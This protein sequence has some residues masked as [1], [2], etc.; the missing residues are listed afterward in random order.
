MVSRCTNNEKVDLLFITYFWR[1][2]KSNTRHD[3]LM[4]R[5]GILDRLIK[6]I[7]L[8]DPR[9][10]NSIYLIFDRDNV[11]NTL[12]IALRFVILNQLVNKTD[13]FEH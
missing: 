1:M 12:D 3:V 10:I 7:D 11:Q 13:L 5:T 9:S 2:R 8:F 6:N 4:S